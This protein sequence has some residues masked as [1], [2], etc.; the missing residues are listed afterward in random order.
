[1]TEPSSS[2]HQEIFQES[3]SASPSEDATIAPR[4]KSKDLPE[5]D[6]AQP[7]EYTIMDEFQSLT[8]LR[9]YQMDEQALLAESIPDRPLIGPLVPLAMLREEYERGSQGFVRQIDWLMSHGHIGIRRTKGDGDCFYRSLAFAYCER[10]MHAPDAELAVMSAISSIEATPAL[11]EAAGFQPLVFEDFYEMFLSLVR[12]ILA[13]DENGK[14]LTPAALLG[15]FN[16]P[17]TSNSIV[18]YLRMLTSAQIRSDPDISNFLLSPETAEFVEPRV[19]CE[20]FVEAMG[21]EADHPQMQALAQALRVH[22]S[23]A[24]LDGHSSGQN[25]DEVTFVHLDKA[26]GTVPGAEPVM[27]LYRPGHYDILDTRSEDPMDYYT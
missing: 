13:P 11:L 9:E 5:L 27:L 7:P 15:A 6:E 21:K 12:K 20:H 16:D 10:I 24:Y 2:S 26:V 18:V 17:E 23:V 1:M 25:G 8:P 3:P 14:V 4:M 19:F 22:V